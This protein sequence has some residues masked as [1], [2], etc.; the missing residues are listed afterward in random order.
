MIRLIAQRSKFIN[1][2]GTD[3]DHGSQGERPCD[4]LGI[5][6]RRLVRLGEI[7]LDSD[8][9]VLN[10]STSFVNGYL[11]T[12]TMPGQKRKREVETKPAVCFLT[13]LFLPVIIFVTASWRCGLAAKDFG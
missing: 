2:F 8:F 13:P 6:V 7:R 9:Q 10:T 3:S 1:R 5:P 11:S 4:Q 12:T